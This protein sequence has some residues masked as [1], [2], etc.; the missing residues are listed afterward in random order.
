MSR[1]GPARRL[2]AR[3]RCGPAPSPSANTRRRPLGEEPPASWSGSIKVF[4]ARTLSS[5]CRRVGAFC[6]LKPR[7]TRRLFGLHPVTTCCPQRGQDHLPR[8]P[9]AFGAPTAN[10]NPKTHIVCGRSHPPSHTPAAQKCPPATVRQSAARFAHRLLSNFLPC[11]V[12]SG[13]EARRQESRRRD[14]VM[15]PA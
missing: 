5:P 2:G 11:I 6:G 12:L 10:G 7:A 14:S 4:K 1:L 15:P 8:P 13:S 3:R 9:I